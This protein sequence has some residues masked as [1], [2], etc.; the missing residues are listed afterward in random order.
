VGYSAEGR[1]KLTILV[2]HPQSR[3]VKMTSFEC[4]VCFE[5]SSERL[6]LPKLTTINGDTLRVGDCN[7]PVCRSCMAAFV[8]A[9]VEDQYVFGICCPIEGCKNELYEQ[10]VDKLVVAGAL[11]PGVATL[12]AKLRKQDYT[13]RLSDVCA[14]LGPTA[15]GQSMRVCPRCSVIIQKS[16]G[17]DSFGCICGHKFQFHTAPSVKDVKALLSH[18]QT[19][20]NM[21]LLGA[22][23]RMVS[24]YSTKGIPNYTRVLSWA[25]SKQL[26]LDSAEVYE[27]ARLRQ[28]AALI[29]FREGRRSRKNAKLH[30]L[31]S[32][33]LG[34]PLAEARAVAED[35]TAGDKVAWGQIRKARQHQSQAS[36]SE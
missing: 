27:Q 5:M 23:D 21:S 24:A 3:S 26:S 7:H 28:P 2:A 16:E 9:R 10:D 34:V 8:T 6:A 25:V 35:A 12:M 1:S 36:T 11:K 32:A 31:L 4:Q 13:S 19:Q 18:C 14:D 33:Q 22:I 15:G 17:C 29:Q 30:E 20:H